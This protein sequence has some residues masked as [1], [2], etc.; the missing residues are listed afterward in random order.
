MNLM[1]QRVLCH[2]C[3]FVLYEGDEL[4]P[5]YEIVQTYNGKCPN[6]AKRLSNM[7]RKVDIE[8]VEAFD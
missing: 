8:P 2:N 4:K 5:P 7:P 3:G 1:P 6:C